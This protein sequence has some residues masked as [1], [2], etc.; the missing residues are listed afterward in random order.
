MQK[1]EENT[2]QGE[3]RAQ[4]G[5]PPYQHPRDSRNAQAE[6]SR[7]DRDR[8]QAREACDGA[9]EEEGA[10]D[11]VVRRDDDGLPNPRPQRGQEALALL[12]IELARTRHNNTRIW[13][14]R[15]ESQWPQ[16]QFR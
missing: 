12:L 10:S 13:R 16:F 3:E 14:T 8:R 4:A 5:D 9:R 1:Q 11:A 15:L 6:H 7:Q 2:A